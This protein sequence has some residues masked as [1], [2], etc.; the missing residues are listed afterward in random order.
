MKV[1]LYKNLPFVQIENDFLIFS[2]YRLNMIRVT[3]EEFKSLGLEAYLE[4]HKF[5]ECKKYDFFTKIQKIGFTVTTDCNLSC[6]YCYALCLQRRDGWAGGA[7]TEHA[8]QP[9]DP[10]VELHSIRTMLCNPT[11]AVNLN[12]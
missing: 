2:P 9:C 4:N 11:L 12:L 6:K 10:R 3:K 1:G 5:H 7:S 8:M